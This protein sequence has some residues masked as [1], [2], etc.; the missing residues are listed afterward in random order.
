VLS[1]ENE[2]D[3][4]QLKTILNN[5]VKEYGDEKEVITI[6]KQFTCLWEENLLDSLFAVHQKW[7]TMLMT[8]NSGKI[9]FP[10]SLV[11][12]Q[13]IQNGIRPE[14]DS[15]DLSVDCESFRNLYI[16][17]E[18]LQSHYLGR[19]L[20]E[21]DLWALY[22]SD[23]VERILGALDQF[24]DFK[25]CLFLKDEYFIQLN[26]VV[27]VPE[28]EL[29]F[30]KFQNLLISFLFEKQG[31]AEKTFNSELK[32]VLILL[33]HSGAILSDSPYIEFKHITRSYTTLFRLIKTDITNFVDKRYYNGHVVCSHCN[34]SYKLLENEAPTDFSACYCGGD[35]E[36][37]SH[38]I[39]Q[40]KM[41][42]K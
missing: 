40:T 26:E 19:N 8:T 11:L 41:N 3:S 30:M 29:F 22:Q 14:R 7:Q 36:Y 20:I 13:A 15:Q 16:F 28:A 18:K 32:K 27:W 38:D 33:A 5:F 39:Y 10:E 1:L 4:N 25:G 34:E 6:L 2:Y 37:I 24:N 23:I 12:T 21:D 17:L 9:N 35:L 31:I 42:K